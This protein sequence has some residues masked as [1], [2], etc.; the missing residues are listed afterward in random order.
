MSDKLNLLKSF[1]LTHK[2]SLT[3][4]TIATLGAAVHVKDVAG[5]WAE[6]AKEHGVIDALKDTADQA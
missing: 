6:F 5:E 1:A 2:T 3:F 4:A